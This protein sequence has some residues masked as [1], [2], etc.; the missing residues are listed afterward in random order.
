MIGDFQFG[1]NVDEF[2]LVDFSVFVL[3]VLCEEV[4]KFLLL[5]HRFCK[6][7]I[8]NYEFMNRQLN[9]IVYSYHTINYAKNV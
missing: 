9:L 4:D 2:L 3:V 1:D 5:G 7:Y 6:R 8:Y